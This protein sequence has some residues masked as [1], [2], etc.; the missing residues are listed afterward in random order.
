MEHS[1][2][3][4]GS[5]EWA[6]SSAY[7]SQSLAVIDF[8]AS[9]YGGNPSLLGIELLNEPLVTSVPVDVL[10]TY[11]TNGY[12]TVRKH[13]DTAYVIM[14]QRIGA[15]DPHEL[16]QANN[17]F[18]NVVIDVHYYNLF[19]D[20]FNNKSAKDNIEFVL[21][22]RKVELQALNSANGPLIF[23]GEWT[24]EWKV[25][26]ASRSDY[27]EFSDAQLQV[28][29]KASFGWSYWTLK[30]K[31]K[32]WDFKWNA[33]HKYLKAEGSWASSNKSI[34]CPF[35]IFLLNLGYL[36]LWAAGAI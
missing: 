36:H 21:N 9:R 19:D 34:L 1:A 14:C 8:L 15:A 35:Y 12:Q 6:N 32:H 22:N 18:S 5:A 28:Y 3:R 26:G 23:V 31:Q 27:K 20:F 7:I 33:K 24:N 25:A 29:E 10:V 11:Y 4:D 16:Y 30:N 13:S 17:G 2:S